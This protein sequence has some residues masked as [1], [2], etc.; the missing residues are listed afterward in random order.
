MKKF[1]LISTL[2]LLAAT[3]VRA[4]AVVP[5][6]FTDPTNLRRQA[7]E[8][9]GYQTPEGLKFPYVS[10]YY[11]KP[12][13]LTTEE[14]SIGYFVTDWDSSKIR[15]LDD[16]FRFDVFLEY[17]AVSN[18]PKRLVQKGVKSGDGTFNLG[19]LPKGDYTVGVWAKDPQ[20]RE[21]HRVW[22]EFRVIDPQD[23]VI[24]ADKVYTVKPADLIEYGISNHGGFG[25]EVIVEIGELPEK[26]K[27]AEV[28][29]AVKDAF[30]AKVASGTLPKPG[31][32][33]GYTILIPAQKGR[34]LFRSFEKARIIFDPG[35]DTNTVE[36]AAI[37]TAE[38]LQKLI[39][40][41]A[42]AGF[43]KLVLLPGTYRVSAFRR[44]SLPDYFTLDLNGSTIKENAFTGCSGVIVK[45]SSVIDAHL[46]NGTL[47]GD[48]YEHD[49]AHSPNH[50][51]WPMGF[52]FNAAARDCTVENVRIRNITGYGGGNGIGKDA[53]GGLHHFAQGVGK[54]VPG[55]LRPA[56]GTLD[57][58]DSARFTTGFIDVTKPKQHKYLQVSKYLGYQGRATRSWQMVAC[59]YDANKNFLF[60]ET[61]F[62]YRGVPIPEKAAFIRYSIEAGSLDEANKCGL[63]MSLFRVPQNCAVKNCVFERCRAVGYAASAMKNML[64]EG[65]EFMYSGES[66]AKC[67][68]DAEDGWDQMQDVYF[69]RNWFH[70][71]P[72]NNSILTCAGHNFI[73]EKNRCAIHFWGRTHSPCVRDNDVT[74]ATY[75]CDSRLRSGYGRFE[76]NRYSKS[77]AISCG[78][79]KTHPGW[80][81]VVSGLDMSS[82]N[83]FKL[84]LGP[85]GRLVG[86]RVANRTA[87]IANASGCVITN[88]TAAFIPNG[89]WFGMQVFGSKFDNFYE[90]NT[91]TKCVFKDTTFH[92]F[93]G[94]IQTFED[95]VFANCNFSM[96]SEANIRFTRCKFIGGGA[97]G[98]WWSKPAHI[99]YRECT[100]EISGDSYLRIPVYTVGKI[101]FERC[102]LSTTNAK[103]AALIDI[104]DLRRQPTD[105]QVGSF[106]VRDCTFGHG[107]AKVIV[108]SGLRNDVSPKKVTI[109]ASGD[110]FAE[111]SGG[112]IASGEILA[113]W[114][115]AQ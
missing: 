38:G 4:Q 48:Y 53:R 50:S 115:V 114:S 11:V 39:N 64:F 42:A 35:Y 86:C 71:N 111:A 60:S 37:A 74:S 106:V 5:G 103:G 73:L 3:S 67:A 88:C 20:G 8:Q 41:K 31:S 113:T 70:D 89:N 94:A 6:E 61:L 44:I 105:D 58:T 54:Y 62:Q 59:W 2:T 97:S 87:R 109:E 100:F 46:V 65:N 110:T 14:A 22:H 13:V 51:E 78:R 25:R 104:H 76:N 79:S 28:M 83:G 16:S 30:D 47:E 34:V 1:V 92:N 45:I 26:P 91:Y 77:L 90:T 108:V 84:D 81:F 15:F 24:P 98:G 68:Y 40:D 52:T 85:S 32:V 19:R 23:A 55:G 57:E 99:E 12:T 63:G 96:L 17:Y 101:V 27:D 9:G 93:K 112:V 10:T 72:V 107:I 56:D 33:P 7:A 69:L 18:T 95:C 29:K 49:Y 43:R 75:S 80:D 102:N 82:T 21:S 36:Q 66:L